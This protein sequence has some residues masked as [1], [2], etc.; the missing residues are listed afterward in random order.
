MVLRPSPQAIQLLAA[1]QQLEGLG[2]AWPDVL[3][4]CKPTANRLQTDYVPQLTGTNDTQNVI[5]C[6]TCSPLE[7]SHLHGPL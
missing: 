6:S 5:Y 4:G 1:L 2:K 7:F 3:G